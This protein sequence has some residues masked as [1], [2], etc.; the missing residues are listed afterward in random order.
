LET[1]QKAAGSSDKRVVILIQ[2]DGSFLVFPCPAPGSM[3]PADVARMES[4]V[5]STA[6]R[7]ISVIAHTALV[8]GQKK[9]MAV[10]GEKIFGAAGQAIPF[11]GLLLGL[12]YIGHT[13]RV[14]DGS[15]PPLASGCK[16]ADVLIV[17]SAVRGKLQDG[18]QAVACASMRNANIFVHDRQSFQLR[19]VNKV[20]DTEDHIE[21]VSG[22]A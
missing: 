10:A 2:S 5:P 15:T 3:P 21:F 22:R 12:A 14:F 11:F 20:G 18:W 17:D 1:G 19:I 9:P 7:N 8:T 13:V 16:D 6:K 4:V